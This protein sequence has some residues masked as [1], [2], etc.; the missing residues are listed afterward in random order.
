M[1]KTIDSLTS[2]SFL[3]VGKF[4]CLC[5]ILSTI[6]KFYFTWFIFGLL[7]TEKIACLY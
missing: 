3:I 6:N 4:L 7:L 2:L 1:S 5:K